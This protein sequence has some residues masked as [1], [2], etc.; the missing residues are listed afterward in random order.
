MLSLDQRLEGG[1]FRREVSHGLVK[2][3]RRFDPGCVF[4]RGAA[5]N[6]EVSGKHAA[7]TICSSRQI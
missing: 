6:V 5:N 7:N 1:V 4:P 3:F 2:L